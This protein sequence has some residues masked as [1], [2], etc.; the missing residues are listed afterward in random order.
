MPKT[1]PD[2]SLN[3]NGIPVTGRKT[4]VIT[5][6]KFDGLREDGRPRFALCETIVA[7]TQNDPR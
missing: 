5:V 6:E 1:K 2:P 7:S 4:R 3:R